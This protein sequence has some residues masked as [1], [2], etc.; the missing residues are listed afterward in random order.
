VRDVPERP[1]DF[2]A[3][4]SICDVF[5]PRVMIRRQR[6]SPIGTVTLTSYF[7]A[8]S[9][10]LGRVGSRHLLGVARAQAYRDGFFDQSAE[11]W[12]PEGELL[13]TSHQMVYFK[14]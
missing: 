5:F 8:D 9:Q 13:A 1:L 6:W 12:S 7:H 14:D 2:P 11:V 4:A 3:L 10:T